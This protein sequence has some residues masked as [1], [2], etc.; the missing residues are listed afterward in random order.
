MEKLPQ[1]AFAQIHKSY[2]ISIRKIDKIER[3]QVTLAERILPLS[4][5]FR[6]DLLSRLS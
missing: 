6:D 5:S 3:H 2:I 1:G 4:A